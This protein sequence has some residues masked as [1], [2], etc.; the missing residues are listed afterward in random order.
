MP[1]ADGAKLTPILHVPPAGTPA[2]QPLLARL[3]NCPLTSGIVSKSLVLPLLCKV[4]DLTGAL[5]VFTFPKFSEVG[6]IVSFT[7]G[8]DVGDAVGVTVMV[9]DAV[10]VFVGVAVAVGDAV[11]VAVAVGVMVA[12]AVAVA[13]GVAV[14]VAVAVGVTVGDVLVVGDGVAV[15]VALAVGVALDVAVGVALEVGVGGTLEVAV[16]VGLAVDVGVGVGDASPDSNA[17]MSH[18]PLLSPG[19]GRGSPR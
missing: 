4:I 13:L 12:V 6:A 10:A 3:K 2:A 15:F 1:A 11:A 14:A 9:A 19:A 17:P 7:D 16:G 8:V 18:A 5:P